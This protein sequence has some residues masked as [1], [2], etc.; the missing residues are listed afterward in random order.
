MDGTREYTWPSGRA[1]DGRRRIVEIEPAA[2]HQRT[3]LVV[4]SREEVTELMDMVM[5]AERA[6]TDETKLS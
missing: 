4:G 6:N 3:P 1:T 2:L 5:R